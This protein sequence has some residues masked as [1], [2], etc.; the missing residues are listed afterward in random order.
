MRL[1][2]DNFGPV[3]NCDFDINN[4]NAFI[5]EQASG[6]S[7]VCKIIYYCVTI[8]DEIIKLIDSE[9]NEHIDNNLKFFTK[10]LK[11]KFVKFFGLTYDIPR[12]KIEFFYGSIIN[13]VTIN[14]YFDN[15][16]NY[17][18]INFSS[19]HSPH[20]IED[21]L[22]KIMDFKNSNKNEVFNGNI[23]ERIE[24][25]RKEIISEV[26]KLFGE[27]REII[28]IPSARSIPSLFN[29][30]TSDIANLFSE[31]VSNL[32]SD[33]SIYSVSDKL[34]YISKQFI[35]TVYDQVKE[36]FSN[37]IDGLIRIG[38]MLD[39]FDKIKRQKLKI[40]QG[41]IEE[42]IK[43]EYKFD[44]GQD[45]IIIGDNKTPV[46]LNF[47]SSG[48]QEALWILHMLYLIIYDE[49]NVML[50]IE[51]PETHI[52]TEAQDKILKLILLTK[53]YNKKNVFF[54]TTHS[55]YILTSICNALLANRVSKQQNKV[56]RVNEILISDFWLNPHNTNVFR[57][58]DGKL[59]NIKS[60]E[61]LVF[62]EE[63]D[64]LVQD[65]IINVFN[66]LEDLERGE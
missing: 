41:L 61:G 39:L 48:Q 63:I 10:Q 2:I 30:S 40:A 60:E 19:Y 43:G 36:R 9:I 29:F 17:L 15:D 28:Y 35:F 1:K 49:K 18:N 65:E 58:R 53:N 44:K 42:I 51:E 66:N 62:T 13:K 14:S 31:K 27:T 59:N 23:Q 34:D 32:K 54:I 22:D 37:G 46:R 57:L 7:T 45:V 20:G 25:F 64:T 16:R 47:A 50:F 33:A 3:K 6:K 4:F 21:I 5:G 56:K 11:H 26:F 24:L 8:R 12:F 55:P 52:F 38:D